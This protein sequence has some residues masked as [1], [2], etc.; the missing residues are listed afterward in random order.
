MTVLSLIQ[1]S[2]IKGDAVKVKQFVEQAINDGVDLHK[3]LNE[4]LIAGMSIVGEK[5]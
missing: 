1:E 2:L 4:G 5:I 3:I